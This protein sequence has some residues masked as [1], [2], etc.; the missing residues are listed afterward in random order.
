L[1]VLELTRYVFSPENNFSGVKSQLATQQK[2]L[3]LVFSNV[4]FHTNHLGVPG[5]A[6]A[7]NAKSSSLLWVFF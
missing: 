6:P 3:S 2:H 5:S 4:F 7:H 1:A